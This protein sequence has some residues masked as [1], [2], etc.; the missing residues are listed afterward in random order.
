M[1]YIIDI[2]DAF[3]SIQIT[4]NLKLYNLISMFFKYL[5]VIIIYYFIFNIIKMIYLDIKGTNNMN[6]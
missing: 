5:F 4:P 6:Y 3:F 1:K 2:L